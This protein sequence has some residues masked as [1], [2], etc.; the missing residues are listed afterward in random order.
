MLWCKFLRGGDGILMA[1]NDFWQE[2]RRRL[3]L[4]RH[5]QSIVSGENQAD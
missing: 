3:S 4:D 1:E 2:E 5:A